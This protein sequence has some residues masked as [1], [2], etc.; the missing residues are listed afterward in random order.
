MIKTLKK[1]F[2]LVTVLIFSVLILAVASGIYIFML[3]L[4]KQESKEI[5]EFAINGYENQVRPPKKGEEPEF[6]SPDEPISES[7]RRFDP[8][9]PNRMFRNWITA[10]I[11]ENGE[12]FGIFY[13]MNRFADD[14]DDNSDSNITSAAEQIFEKGTES[15]SLSI[16]GI[17]YSYMLKYGEEEP[18][19]AKIVFLDRSAETATLRRLMLSVGV[20]AVIGI[21]AVIVLCILLSGWAVKPVEEAWKRQKDFIANASHELKTP[22]TVIAANTDVIT[23]NV[24][25]TVGSQKKWFGNIKEEIS[26]MSEIIGSMLYLAKEDRDEEK[27]IMSEFDCSEVIEGVC[28]L[29]EALVYENGKSMETM[30]PENITCRGDK[31]RIEQLAH[32][33]IDNAVKYSAQGSC[34]RVSLHK[35]RSKTCLEVENSGAYISPEDL[36][37]IF[38]RFYRTDKSHNSRGGVGL[39]LAIAKMIADKHNGTITASSSED[40]ITKFAFIW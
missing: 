19:Y 8:S 7:L 38:E 17:Y 11:N 16:E 15:G 5:M 32:I 27:L 26:R 39:G 33:L 40:G 28:L 29:F 21:A 18:Y 24:E 1:R 14:A 37:H 35:Q 36:P 30:I 4:E 9:S 23:S 2:I 22:L 34:I 10:E 31:K 20:I 6:F 25:N 3:N 13:S 12:V